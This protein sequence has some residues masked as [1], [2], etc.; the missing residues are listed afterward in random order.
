MRNK[1]IWVAGH[2][3]MVGA[4]DARRLQSE[5][6]EVLATP[7]ADLDLRSQADVE[8][9]FEA[10]S[11]DAVILAAARVGG[12]K[13]NRD[14]P[15]SFL[16]DNLMIEANVIHAAYGHGVKKLLFLGSSCIY[17]KLASQPIR[18]EALLTGALETTNE[19]YAVAKIAGI[20][21]CGSY[22]KQYGCDFISAM[23][24]NLYGP[25]DTYDQSRSHVIPA[26]I[27]KMHAA[28][29]KNLPSIVLWGTGVPLREFLYV[30]DL[31]DALVFLLKNYGG[32]GHVN[33]GSGHEI[34][35]MA[36]AG[37]IAGVVGYGGKIMFDAA[38]P[39]GA[40]RKL[41]DSVR[42]AGMGWKPHTGL[43]EGLRAA[44]ADYLKKADRHAAA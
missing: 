12:I 7:R 11:P 14:E 43:R 24:C 26:L 19:S 16:Y 1:K 10:N 4:A 35:I 40:P 39:D 6:C 9:W 27:M 23:P 33:V 37:E 42:L 36:L 3:G 13:A 20:K 18:E 5:E 17:P 25:G 34:S 28:K 44:Y 30:D 22:R 31:A 32:E 2:N 15:A 41:M 38:M 21:M 29:M 8:S